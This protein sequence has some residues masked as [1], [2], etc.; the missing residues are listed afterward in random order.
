MWKLLCWVRPPG[1][2]SRQTHAPSGMTLEN[3]TG[4]RTVDSGEMAKIPW[5][6]HVPATRYLPKIPTFFSPR[7]NLCS[8]STKSRL[9]YGTLMPYTS[10]LFISSL[11]YLF[12]FAHYQNKYR[13]TELKF[14]IFVD[15]RYLDWGGHMNF[16]RG[17]PIGRGLSS[18]LHRWMFRWEITSHRSLLMQH[19]RVEQNAV[20]TRPS[21]TYREIVHQNFQTVDQWHSEQEHTTQTDERRERCRNE[22]RGM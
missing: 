21:V 9:F 22:E 16:Y 18:H 10:F 11:L 13:C 19:K 3:N 12:F 2:R 5:D 8:S 20:S 4:R 6:K 14:T 17:Q 1:K 7:F 15:I